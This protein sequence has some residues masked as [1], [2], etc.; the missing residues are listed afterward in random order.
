MCVC[1]ILLFFIRLI[2]STS[3]CDIFFC[4]VI[5]ITSII[6]LLFFGFL[7]FFSISFSYD[8][9]YPFHTGTIIFNILFLFLC[10][11]LVTLLLLFLCILSSDCCSCHP[12]AIFC[13]IDKSCANVKYF[14]FFKFFSMVWSMYVY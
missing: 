11:L 8:I 6:S 13:C 5:Q 9:K 12:L 1:V 4:H 2:L 7:S 10:V 14:F 3:S